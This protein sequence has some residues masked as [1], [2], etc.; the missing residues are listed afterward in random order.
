MKTFTANFKI[1]TEEDKQTKTSKGKA[2]FQNG[3]KLNF[4]FSEPYGDKIVSD[5]KIMWV[6]VAK[7]KAVGR[8]DFK[9]AGSIFTATGKEGLTALFKRYHYKFDSP[10]QP[11]KTD[12]GSSYVLELNEKTASGGFDRILLYVDADKFLIQ[13]LTAFSPSGRKVELSFSDI[14]INEDIASNIFTYKVSG[15]E[16]IVENPLTT[17]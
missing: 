7:L 6:Y 17:E 1:L 5:G 4:T 9:N 12:A 2:Y 15:N 8:Q 11:R 14:Q 10:E 16:K 3:G 13:K